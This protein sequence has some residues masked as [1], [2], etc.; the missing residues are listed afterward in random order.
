MFC[1]STAVCSWS[2]VIRRAFQLLVKGKKAEVEGETQMVSGRLR[3]HKATP[4]EEAEVQTEP[5]EEGP[6]P[7]VVIEVPSAAPSP[8]VIKKKSKVWM[9]NFLDLF[10]SKPM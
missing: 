5:I 10:T 8:R 4:C 1:A 2:C 9:G 3:P 7:P 6:P